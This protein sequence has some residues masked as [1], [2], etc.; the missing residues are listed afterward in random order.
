MTLQEYLNQE[1]P[2]RMP[3]VL[4]QPEEFVIHLTIKV[5]VDTLRLVSIPAIWDR[6]KMSGNYVQVNDQPCLKTQDEDGNPKKYSCF[7]LPE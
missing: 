5:G 1:N 7:Y 2:V 4:L 3:K 6:F